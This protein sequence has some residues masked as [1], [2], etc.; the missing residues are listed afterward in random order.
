MQFHEL[1]DLLN[2]PNRKEKQYK[3]IEISNPITSAISIRVRFSYV[4]SSSID[5]RISGEERDVDHFSKKIEELI[6]STKQW[7]SFLGNGHIGYFTV[8][9]IIT[10]MVFLYIV[11]IFGFNKTTINYLLV[12]WLSG[13]F[14]SFKI[15]SYLFPINS[16][17][18]GDGI[19]RIKTKN[20]I[21]SIIL[22]AVF[23]PIIIGIMVNYLT[24]NF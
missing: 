8:T 14:V 22:S 6:M 5:Y 3:Q 1:D 7:F 11:L 17:E 24:R 23:L 12:I 4:E 21:R 19:E 2:H 10:I 13:S 20:N 16:F 9:L 18:L 15:R